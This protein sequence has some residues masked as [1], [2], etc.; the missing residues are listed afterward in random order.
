MRKPMIQILMILL[1]VAGYMVA[2]AQDFVVTLKGDTLHGKVKYFNGTGVRYAGANS[3]YLQ[4]LPKEGKKRTFKLLD[5]IAFKMND[6]FYYTIK[7]QDSYSFMKVLQP[8][9]LT[10]YAYQ[11]E[12]QTTWDGRYFVKRDGTILE[13]PNLAF[14]KRVSQ[15][16]ADCPDVVKKIEAGDLSRSNLKV[17]VEEYNACVQLKT[18]PKIEKS[19]AQLAWLNLETVVKNLSEF[20]KKKDA[21]EMI[22]EVKNKLIKKEN[23]PSF[24]ISGIKDALKDQHSIQETLDAAL[25]NVGSN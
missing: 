23:I 17:L 1:F 21:L 13:V 16:L 15:F 12:G 22:Q 25:A 24:L 7:F 9:Y 8:G 2:S 10:L 19:P 20:D 6:D 5:V 14:K 3:T 18:F 11:L 4:L